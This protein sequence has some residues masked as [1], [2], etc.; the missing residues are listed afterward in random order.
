MHGDL[1]ACLAAELAGPVVDL[2]GDRELVVAPAVGH[3]GRRAHRDQRAREGD[4]EV[5]PALGGLEI[6]VDL[7]LQREAALRAEGEGD[8]CQAA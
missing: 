2:G 1:D 3:D 5:D 8:E 6:G 4:G 7:L